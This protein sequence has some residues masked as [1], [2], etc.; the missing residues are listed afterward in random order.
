[1]NGF[2]RHGIIDLTHRAW[3]EMIDIADHT[4]SIETGGILLGYRLGGTVRVVGVAEVLDPEATETS[5]TLRRD[6][7]QARLDEIRGDF[8]EGS[9]VGFVGD[10]HIHPQNSPPSSVDRRSMARLGRLYRRRM[11]SIVVVREGATWVPHGLAA[12]WARSR[13]CAIQVREIGEA[14]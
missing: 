13:T 6:A 11:V 8:P 2:G 12:T 10:W 1:M 14:Q 3:A 4:G 5:F 9:P 7:A